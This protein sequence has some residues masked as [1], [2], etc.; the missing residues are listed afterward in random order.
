MIRELDGIKPKIDHSVYLHDTAE[1]MGRVRIGPRSSLWP[2]VVLRGDVEEISIGDE[3]NI[4]DNTVVHTDFGIPTSLGNGIT[5]GHS[6]VLH[7]CRIMSHSL[8]GMGAILLNNVVVEEEVIVGAGAVVPPDM[9]VP[10]GHLVLGV[11]AK[12]V[13][14]LTQKEVEYI[15]KNARDYI[16][17]MEKAKKSRCL[18]SREEVSKG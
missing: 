3:T 6:A 4:Q 14:P 13:R 7:G 8:I 15:Y 9:V 17:L 10:R 5:V 11:P 16:T 12:V 2:Y 18:T 1:V